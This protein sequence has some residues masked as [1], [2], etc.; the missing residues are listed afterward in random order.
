MNLFPDVPQDIVLAGIVLIMT[1]F[2][3]CS[4]V[5]KPHCGSLSDFGNAV[6]I[7]A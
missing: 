4:Y 3:P 6:C 1:E 2:D 5:E 7:R